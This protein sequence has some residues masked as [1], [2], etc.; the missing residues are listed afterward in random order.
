MPRQPASTRATDHAT[1]SFG[2][3]S[4]PVAVYTGTVSDHGISRKMFVERA[5]V[6]EDGN[7]V[8]TDAGSAKLERHPVG[9]INVDKITH[10]EVPRTE[11]IKM[12]ETEYGFV[13]VE[14]HEIE[15]LF[16]IQPKSIQVKEFQPLAL[17]RQGH[18]VPKALYYVEADRVHDGKR[19]VPN[20]AAQSSLALMFKA[21]RAENVMAVV[22]FTSR[23]VPK[24]AVLLPDGTLWVVYHT[25]ELREQRELPEIVVAD[26]VVEQARALIRMLYGEEPLDLTDRRTQLIQQFADDK[27]TAGDFG[28]TAE[29]T[30]INA[31]TQ[32]TQDLAELLRASV[33]AA[34]AKKKAS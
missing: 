25:D 21:M 26:A 14:D 24:P 23:G 31:V 2:L 27:A 13:F 30:E 32:P 5:A 18:Y 33:E 8:L 4:I 3:V 22:D 7:T 34:K 16:T 20:P 17:F 19:K 29:V 28:K 1:L 11:V 15:Q 6:D 12:I 9:Y 10:E